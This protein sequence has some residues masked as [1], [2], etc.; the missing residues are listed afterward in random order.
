V[1][2]AVRRLPIRTRLAVIYTGLLAAALVV[3]GSGAFLVLRAQL[4]SSFDA[5]LMAN[6]DHAAGAFAQDVDASGHLHPTTR[7]L[8]QLAST[9]GRVEIL[10]PAGGLI[11]D[12]ATAG[13]PALPISNADIES[14]SQHARAIHAISLGGD[15]WRLLLEPIVAPD[16]SIVGY[17][18]WAASTRSMT[19]LLGTVGLALLLGGVAVSVLAFWF[20]R[21]LARRALAPVADVTDTARA[22][23]LSGDFG[24]NV[25]A[26]GSTGDEVGELA[27]AFNEMLAALEENHKALQRFL[28]D[29][30]HELRTPLTSIRASLELATRPS[31]PAGERESL[32]ADAL[33]EAGR[34]ERLVGDLLSLARAES[35]ARLEVASVEIDAV[36]LETVRQAATAAPHVR[37]EVAAI[38]AAV[39]KGDRDRLKELFLIV[40]DNAGRYTPAGGRV[41]AELHVDGAGV[42]VSVSDTGIGIPEE[43]RGRVFERLFRGSAAR[44]GRPSGT[45]LGLAI[46]KWIVEAHGGSIGVASGK[47]GGTVVSIVLPGSRD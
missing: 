27:V 18:V 5:G 25:D 36:L 15:S 39:V 11:L 28:G 32:L 37:M 42:H 4:D 23:S 8:Q 21:L 13:T 46:A 12:S 20:G 17:V 30:S 31:L 16:H 10:D 38:E 35:G 44:A 24:A 26:G 40:L 2:P 47:D 6:A 43:D 33:G 34:M 45:G 22:I 3:F 14:A 29:A 41:S 9:G 19:D 7:L 1:R